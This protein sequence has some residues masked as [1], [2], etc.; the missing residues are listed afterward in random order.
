MDDG[1]SYRGNV[2]ETENGFECLYWNSHFILE[3]GVDPFNSFEDEDGL[4]PH[5]FCRS[6]K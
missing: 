4:G 2:S 6:G 3:N 1:E 5:N